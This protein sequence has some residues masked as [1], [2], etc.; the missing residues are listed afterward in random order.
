MMPEEGM[1]WSQADPDP[2]PS[3]ATS[4]WVIL[5]QLFNLFKPELPHL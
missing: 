1:T 3:S 4:S 2:D 5:P